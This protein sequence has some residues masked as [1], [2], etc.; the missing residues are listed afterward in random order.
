MAQLS[1]GDGSP[2]AVLSGVTSFISAGGKLG[3][4]LSGFVFGMG[5]SLYIGVGR[6]IN[7][8]VTFITTPFESGAN[9]IGTLISGILA[10]PAEILE[11]TAQ[12]TGVRISEEFGWLAFAVG[13]AVVLGS[14][15]MV[16]Q[17]L[18]QE[19]T[20]DTFVGLPFDTPDL[21]PFEIGVTEEGEDEQ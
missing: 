6:I 16:T 21:G 10:S 20:G 4:L 14:L 7:A 13:V 11:I 9:A 1:L 15:Y 2:T 5:A 8:V 17:Y 3:N 19:E 18:E 12:T